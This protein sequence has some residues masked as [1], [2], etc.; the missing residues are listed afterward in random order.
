M[1]RF[2]C[3]RLL[4]LL[5]TLLGISLVTF[6]A[7]DLAP[8]DRAAA[9]MARIAGA[10]EMDAE[11]YAAALRELRVRFGQVDP[12]T[13]ERLPWLE[14]YGAWLG[15]ALRFEFA[16]PGEDGEKFRR[17]LRQALPV[18]LLLGAAALA[19][20]LLIAIPLGARLGMAPRRWLD[21]LA[22]PLVMVG[23]GVPQYLWATFA[24]LLLGGSLLPSGGLYSQGAA[25]A[26]PLVQFGDLL[27]HLLLPVAVLAMAPAILVVRFLRESV[28]RAARSDFVTMLRAQG[29]PEPVVRRSAL[30]NGLAPLATLLGT[31]VPTLLGGSV[32][33]ETIFALP[34]LGRLGFEAVLQRDYPMVMALTLLASLLT[35][36]SL[37]L[38]DWLHRAVDPRVTLR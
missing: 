8:G 2:T 35:L 34:G 30:R 11:Q 6:A 26:A 38:S 32:V 14:R 3:I 16:G 5:P 29:L 37:W 28:A 36:A 12:V 19:L 27:L 24:L 23:H 20:A 9:E 10:S 18:S 25:R 1:L 17:R 31:M 21:R 22:T 7:V 15:R 33:V 13:G 4:W